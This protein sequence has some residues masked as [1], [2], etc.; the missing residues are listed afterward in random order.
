MNSTRVPTIAFGAG[1]VAAHPASGSD[2]T[3]RPTESPVSGSLQTFTLS[4]MPS[5][6]AHPALIESKADDCAS[7][8]GESVNVVR[9]GVPI[10][11]TTQKRPEGRTT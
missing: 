2:Q 11:T 7:T 9:C 8:R 6:I 4:R 5:G 3:S 1:G 10:S